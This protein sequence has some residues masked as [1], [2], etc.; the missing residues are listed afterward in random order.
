M[1]RPHGMI[2]KGSAKHMSELVN[3]IAGASR[4]IL[5]VERLGQGQRRGN[6]V[7]FP[8][9]ARACHVSGAAL[10]HQ[11]ASTGSCFWSAIP[12]DGDSE[13]IASL[14]VL[15]PTA[16]R[17]QLARSADRL[18]RTTEMVAADIRETFPCEM[19]ETEDCLTVNTGKVRIRIGKKPYS[20]TLLGP[21]GAKVAELGGAER[22][23]IK[24]FD[25]LP[26]GFVVENDRARACEHFRLE[27]DEEILGMGEQFLGMRRRGQTVRN[28]SEDGKGNH[29][30]RMYKPIPFLLSTRGYGVFFNT[31]VPFTAWVG[32]QSAFEASFL[33]EEDVLDYYFFYGP[34]LP[35]V[36]SQYTAL[37][38][39][40]A[41]PPAWSFGLWIS[42]CGYEKAAD[43]RRVAERLRAERIPCDVFHFDP[44]WMGTDGSDCTFEPCPAW[45]DLEDMIRKMRALNFHVSLWQTPYMSEASPA[46]KEGI[47]RGAL[48]V[49]EPSHCPK[50]MGLIDFS[51]PQAVAWYKEKLERLL[52]MGA[53]C[54]KVDFGET[55]PADVKYAGYSGSEMHNLYPLLYSRAAWEITEQVKGK[56]NALIWARPAYA[57]SQRYPIHWSGDPD[58]SFETLACVVKA[59]LSLALAG[60]TFWA[61]DLGGYFS[62]PS[63]ELYMRWTQFAFFCSHVRAHGGTPREPW[64]FGE[65]ALANF[66]KYAALRYSLMPYILEEAAFAAG[67]GLPFMRP[68]I[69]DYQN[70]RCARYIEDEYLF[71]RSLLVAPVLREGA[72]RRELYLPEGNWRSFWNEDVTPGG[73]WIDCDA[74][75]DVLPLFVREGARIERAPL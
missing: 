10:F 66:R 21:S 19:V 61:N 32:S 11:F 70:D 13:M 18:Y 6:R 53:D 46:F 1:A 47:E 22:C 60:F 20:V 5:P 24:Q 42:T 41:M 25:A 2:G 3:E 73:R 23:S 30:P 9:Y 7:D 63:P 44:P 74:P 64:E 31:S 56:G 37:T 17:F 26:T 45:A 29:S 27:H 71:G 15:T 68:L 75:L 34:Q 16:F 28:W 48:I 38:G 52:R 72:R 69:L 8:A 39:R 12:S 58:A 65:E 35:E 33:I 14:D 67:R 55:S 36:I 59:G 50:R 40:A 51:R 57:G 54:I 49:P 4:A 62:T 43:A